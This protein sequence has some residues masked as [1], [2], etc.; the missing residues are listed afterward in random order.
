MGLL[1]PALIDP[2]G[3]GR[4]LAPREKA[5]LSLAEGRVLGMTPFSSLALQ[6]GLMG[7][8]GD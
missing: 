5:G 6:T 2:S 8:D 7:E 4:G 1:R 3:Q